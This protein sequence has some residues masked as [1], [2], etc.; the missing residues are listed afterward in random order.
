MTAAWVV[1]M[2]GQWAVRPR[3][4]PRQMLRSEQRPLI[5]TN[6]RLPRQRHR[7]VFSRRGPPFTQSTSPGFVASI[8][9]TKGRAG[10]VPTTP[11][12]GP[13][14]R[15]MDHHEIDA[16]TKPWGPWRGRGPVICRCR[17]SPARTVRFEA[18][19]HLDGR[20]LPTSLVPTDH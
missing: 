5:S 15:G 4:R 11:P 20:D 14:G 3:T 19:C 7:P 6:W 16:C 18:R 1:S 2:A 12:R 10:P 13:R 9:T 8:W 17:H